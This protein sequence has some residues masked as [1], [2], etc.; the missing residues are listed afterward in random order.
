MLQLEISLNI[1]PLLI[2]SPKGVRRCSPSLF[3][4]YDLGYDYCVDLLLL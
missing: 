1:Y 2:I 3:S 4:G